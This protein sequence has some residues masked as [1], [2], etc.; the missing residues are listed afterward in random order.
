MATHFPA[1]PALPRPEWGDDALSRALGPAPAV[2]SVRRASF[3]DAYLDHR[4]DLDGGVVSCRCGWHERDDH[5]DFNPGAAHIFA[6][7]LGTYRATS[8]D[9]LTGKENS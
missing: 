4:L 7:L 8:F 1:H 2:L 6:V 5:P 9:A 3:E